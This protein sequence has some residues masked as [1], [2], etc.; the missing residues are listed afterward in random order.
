MKFG[1][2]ADECKRRGIVKA[3]SSHDAQEKALKRIMRRLVQGGLAKH[4]EGLR[5]MYR[6]IR[7]SE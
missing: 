4:S 1:P 6:A 7:A 5:G 3:D 2:W